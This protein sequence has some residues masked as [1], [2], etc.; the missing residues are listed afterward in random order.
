MNGLTTVDT[1][2]IQSTTSTL[3]GTLQEAQESY[4]ES[5]LAESVALAKRA[6]GF[7]AIDPEQIDAAFQVWVDALG[8]MGH[9]E[10]V[11]GVCAQWTGRTTR[12]FGQTGALLVLANAHRRLGDHARAGTLI[13]D[14]RKMAETAGERRQLGKALRHQGDLCWLQGDNDKAL[15]LLKQA[16]TTLEGTGDA[17]G[18][19]TTLIS[20]AIVYHLTGRFYLAIQTLQRA[21]QLS[22]AGGNQ[23]SRWIIFNNM[24]EAYQ[25]LHAMQDALRCHLV[26]VEL[27]RGLPIID[28]ERNRGVDLVGLG[29]Y[30]EGMAHLMLAHEMAEDSGDMETMLQVYYSM[31]EALIGSGRIDEADTYAGR[32]FEEAERRALKPHLTRAYLLM[33]RLCQLRGDLGGAERHLTESA[34]IAQQTADKELIWMSHSALADVLTMSNPPLAAIHQL[35]AADIVRDIAQSIDDSAL[36]QTFQA[37]P[38][39]RR[40]LTAAGYLDNE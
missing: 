1:P 20:T 21:T 40:L 28:L 38:D 29:R 36:R 5:R 35:M 34:Y 2:D 23:V 9:Y 39:I 16:A 15:T 13:E 7:E 18:Q 17:E 27:R 12:V 14:A 30:H 33:G 4:R 25:K 26:A 6:L 31:A 32:L 10:D 8:A 11:I 22:I 24:G 19:V 3:A 37:V